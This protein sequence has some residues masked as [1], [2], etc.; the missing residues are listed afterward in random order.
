MDECPYL[1]V[2]VKDKFWMFCNSVLQGSVKSVLLGDIEIT[3]LL[4]HVHF[5]LLA[6]LISARSPEI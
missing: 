2:R 3:N 4:R 5:D 1:C 6:R